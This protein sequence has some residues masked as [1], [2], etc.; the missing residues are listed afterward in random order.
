MCQMSNV[1]RV[2]VRHLLIS[3]YTIPMPTNIIYF[4]EEFARKAHVSDHVGKTINGLKRMRV[5]HHLDD[6]F[7]R[8]YRKGAERYGLEL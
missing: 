2:I 3:W 6:L 7:T 1:Y 8:E 5:V 4:A